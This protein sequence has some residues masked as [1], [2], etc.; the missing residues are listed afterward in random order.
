[1]VIYLFIFVWFKLTEGV[2]VY[3]DDIAKS[4]IHG[5]VIVT[6]RYGREEDEILGLHFSKE[7][8]LVSQE[9]YPHGPAFTP[10][11]IQTKLVNKYGPNA[12]PFAF[13][14]NKNTPQTVVIQPEEGSEG[15]PCGVYYNVRAFVEDSDGNRSKPD[16]R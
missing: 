10:S 3:S 5:Q 11:K 4:K 9:I 7:L 15:Q 16:K 14:L 6:F 12:V 13:K 1:M 2:I 8:F